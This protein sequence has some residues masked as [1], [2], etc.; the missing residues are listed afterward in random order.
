MS[1]AFRRES[2]EEHLEP[3]FELPLPPGPNLVTRR[4]LAQIEARADEF[5]AAYAAA[6]DDEA[7]K[8]VQRERRY[9]NTRRSTAIVAPPPPP[10]EVAFGA[11]IDFLLNGKPRRVDLVG[12]D[13]A[14]PAE[15]RIP[16]TAPL[17]RA[18]M[19]A[20]VGDVLEFNG[21]E[22]AIEIIAV[23]PIPEDTA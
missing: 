8:L 14:A 9:W 12:S 23:A 21:D 3:K 2:D 5:E 22:D 4:G 15:N 1:V 13:E 6:S 18:M 11:R 16:F 20:E 19:G 10:G 7:R 17:A